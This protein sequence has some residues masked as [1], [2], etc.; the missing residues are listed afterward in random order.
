MSHPIQLYLLLQ[1]YL[2]VLL[3][4]VAPCNKALLALLLLRVQFYLLVQLL[5]FL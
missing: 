2:L 5:L 1:L 4:L 3:V